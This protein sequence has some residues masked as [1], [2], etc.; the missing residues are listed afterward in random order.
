MPD[1]DNNFGGSLVLDDITCNP[2]IAILKTFTVPVASFPVTYPVR[3]TFASLALSCVLHH[4][5]V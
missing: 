4:L 1:E 2:K 5:Q 3:E